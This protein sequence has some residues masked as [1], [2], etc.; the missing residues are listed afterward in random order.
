MVEEIMVKKSGLK[1]PGWIFLQPFHIAPSVGNGEIVTSESH[2]WYEFEI[3]IISSI[4]NWDSQ[5]GRAMSERN[6]KHL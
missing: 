3:H 5:Q 1:S 6:K 2:I 4:A